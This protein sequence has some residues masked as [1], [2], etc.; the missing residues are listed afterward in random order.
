[1]NEALQ[2]FVDSRGATMRVDAAHGVIRGIKILGLTSRNNRRYLPEALSGAI[3]LYDGAKVNIN[4]PKGSPLAPRDYQDR[5]GAIRNVEYRPQQ[6]LFGDLHFNPKHA[7]AEQL[8]W[9]A[10]HAP[11]NVG[12]SHNVE[13]RTSRGGDTVIVEAILK[14]Q[15]VDLVADPATTRG[16]FEQ[17]DATGNGGAL[18]AQLTL[19]QLETQRPDLIAA[20]RATQITEIIELRG[21]VDRLRAA[22]AAAARRAQAKALLTEFA[23]PDPESGD[24]TVRTLISETFWQSLLAAADHETMRSIV[25]ERAQLIRNASDLNGRPQH[26]WPR[27]RDQHD[28][29]RGATGVLDAKAFARALR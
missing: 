25:V 19:E 15:S 24:P 20:A 1:M 9:D 22:E 26:A 8:V 12:L 23:L 17:H 2:E 3:G 4:H 21:E 14:V 7:L 11:E 16:L 27:S 6:G 10:E 29:E 28:A 5:I 13:A 18:L